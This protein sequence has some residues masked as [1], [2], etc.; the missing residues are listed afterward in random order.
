MCIDAFKTLRNRGN[1][2][3]TVFALL[4]SSGIPELE[5]PSDLNY[6]RDSLA[7][8]K[9]ENTATS[10]FNK[11]FEEASKSLSTVLNWAIHSVIHSK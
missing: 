6:I 11:A 9:D 1:L 5:S 3:I 8:T 7:M 10:L 4:L 2:F